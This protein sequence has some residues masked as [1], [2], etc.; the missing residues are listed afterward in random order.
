MSKQTE[1]IALVT[2]ASGGIG[3]S[4]AEKLAANGFYVFAAARRMDKLEAMRTSQIEPLKLDVTDEAAI[5]TAVAHITRSKGRL[6]VLV[7]N[8][9]YGL[10]GT[11]EGLS[12]QAVEHVFAVN[13]L[14]LGRMTQAILPMMRQQRSGTVINISSVVGKVSMPGLGW[15]AASKHAVEGM[16]DALRLEVKQFGI[17]VVLVEPGVIDTGF[18]DVAVNTLDNSNEPPAYA[19]MVAAFRQSVR[20]SYKNAPGPE[21]VAQTVLKALSSN[22]P[23]ARYRVGRDAKLLITARHLLGDG[24]F[25]RA[26]GSRVKAGK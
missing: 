9:G 4:I 1:P 26:V 17:N 14:G 23:K 21:L 12:P 11:I 20:D 19:P 22:S 24:L 6:D 3:K 10:Y 16:T 5:E 8:A 7:N 15:Y 25:D 13:V 2:G 18:E